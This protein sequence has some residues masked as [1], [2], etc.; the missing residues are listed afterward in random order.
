MLF[1]ETQSERPLGQRVEWEKN[2][3]AKLEKARSK[4]RATL[5]GIRQEMLRKD[6]SQEEYRALEIEMMQKMKDQY[7]KQVKRLIDEEME[8]EI[9]REVE[10]RLET[11]VIGRERL[12]KRHEQER[13]FYRSQIERVKEECEMSLTATLAQRNY[14]R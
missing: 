8:R 9:G 1:K 2:Q 4:F 10:S 11:S 13:S 12:K 5:E 6:L 7:W 3:T 14:L